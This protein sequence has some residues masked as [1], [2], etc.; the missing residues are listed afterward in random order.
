MPRHAGV[1][2]A[3]PALTFHLGYIYVLVFQRMRVGAQTRLQLNADIET[4]MVRRWF[5]HHSG[6]Y[7]WM[8]RVRQEFEVDGW[9]CTGVHHSREWR[10]VCPNSVLG[11]QSSPSSFDDMSSASEDLGHRSPFAG[12]GTTC[13]SPCR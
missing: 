1:R 8:L 10:E 13:A 4:Q 3:N 12:I 11:Q 7:A 9:V 2:T 6:I 5:P